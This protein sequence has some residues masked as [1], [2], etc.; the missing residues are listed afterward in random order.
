MPP[1]CSPCPRPR[2]QLAG[3]GQG[4][5]A[6]RR[7]VLSGVS[8]GLASGQLP[9]LP[10]PGAPAHARGGPCHTHA[11][12]PG[13]KV[14]RCAPEPHPRLWPG[15]L[16]P[17][18]AQGRQLAARSSEVSTPGYWAQ[19][20]DPCARGGC[21][22]AAVAGPGLE[23]VCRAVAPQTPV[24]LPQPSLAQ[25]EFLVQQGGPGCRAPEGCGR[26]FLWAGWRGASK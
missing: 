6:T 2:S 11:P 1:P 22:G 19:T 21:W 17:L 25:T 13:T 24:M 3:P 20:R 4:A 7:L 15:F 10:G 8:V 16:G 26:A 23:P 14:P 9:G 5:R 18:G 12:F